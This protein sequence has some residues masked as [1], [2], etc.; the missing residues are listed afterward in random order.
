MISTLPT[1][2]GSRLWPDDLRLTALYF[3]Q[4]LP[5]SIAWLGLPPLL[6]AQGIGLEAIGA[7]GLSVLPWAFKFLW[8]APVERWCQRHGSHRL[9]SVT[10]AAAALTFAGLSVIDI[11]SALP[12]VIALLIL[13]NAI[14]ATQDVATDRV[15]ILRRGA[16][17]AVRVNTT[18][19]IGYTA[20][21]LA[22]STG[23]LLTTSYWSW[24]TFMG[25]AAFWMLATGLAAWGLRDPGATDNAEREP[26]TVRRFLDK[27]LAWR[28]LGVATVHE[29]AIAASDGML[30]AFWI[31]AGIGL[32][33]VGTLTALNILLLGLVGAPFGAW[34]LARREARLPSVAIG[35]ALSAA[36]MVALLGVA[37]QLGIGLT[38][39]SAWRWLYV[40]LPALTSGLDGAASL[41][42]M[43]LFMRWSAGTQPGTDFTL[44]LCAHSLGGMLLASVAGLT[45]AALGYGNYFLLCAALGA[46]AMAYIRQTLRLTERHL[47][48]GERSADRECHGLA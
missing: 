28:L 27:P 3:A 46:A 38:P 45:A 47:P 25:P 22:G 5:M 42:F 35:F 26:A 19:F 33:Q 10:Q 7:L 41:A 1:G 31:D 9:I 4:A 17:G 6:R 20:G 37:V 40:V 2:T 12:A 30:K 24:G 36:L 29:A 13:L 8:A 39:G 18:R 15:A 14:C 21:M 34:L 11:V 23:L 43:T 32:A 48:V 44:F 16:I